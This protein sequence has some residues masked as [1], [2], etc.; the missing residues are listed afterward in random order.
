MPILLT[1]S[2]DLRAGRSELAA[3]ANT[4]FSSSTSSSGLSVSSGAGYTA[5]LS[6]E[7]RRKTRIET[8]FYYSA[9][10]LTKT[11]GSQS[12]SEVG[13]CL[14]FSYLGVARAECA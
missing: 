7:Y 2:S 1:R 12:S 10:S 11:Q 3:G 5:H 13:L 4:I 14:R 6:L 9:N 8:I